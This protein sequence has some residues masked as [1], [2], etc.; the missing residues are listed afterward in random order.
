M[1]EGCGAGDNDKHEKTMYGLTRRR[2][3]CEPSSVTWDCQPTLAPAEAKGDE[4]ITAG[5]AFAHKRRFWVDY[6]GTSS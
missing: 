2:T 5:R 4:S 3:G 6:T 1:S